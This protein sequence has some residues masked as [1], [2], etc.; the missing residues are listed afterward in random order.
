MVFGFHVG[1]LN[2]IQPDRWHK[3][4]DSIFGLGA[5]GVSFFFVLSGFVLAWSA[6]PGDTKLGFWRRRLAKIYPN[7]L[8]MFLIVLLVMVAWGD[9]LDLTPVL[10]NL[11]LVQTWPWADGYAYTVNS[12]S[13]TLC[14]EL[15]FYLCLPFVLPTLRRVPTGWIYAGLIALPLL[16]LLISNPEGDG[17]LFPLVQFVPDHYHWWFT[18]MFPPVRSLEFWT[19]VLAGVLLTRRHWFGPGL[20]TSTAIFLAIYVAC[21][22]WIPGSYHMALLTVAY[23][24]LIGGGAKADLSGARSPWRWPVLVWLG[25]VSFAF[26]LVHVALIGN[27]LR[28]LDRGGKGWDPLPA[29]GVIIVS[30]AGSLFAAWLLFTLVEKPAMKLLVPRRRPPAPTSETSSGDA[31]PSSGDSG[32]AALDPASATR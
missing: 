2:L 1:T 12:V 21:S 13:W 30:V 18:Q 14:C 7:H 10:A 16:I 23:T 8:A 6:R 4:W 25:E 15:F 11:F 27:V 28:L 9:R 26:Y 31:A 19:G 29:A 20:W 17:G 5:S 22:L 3:A 32:S 24:V